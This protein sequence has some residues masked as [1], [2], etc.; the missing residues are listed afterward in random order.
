M[1]KISHRITRNKQ[2][3]YFIRIPTD[4]KQYFSCTFIKRSLKTIDKTTAKEYA[5]SLEYQVSRTLCMLRSRL[6]SETQAATLVSDLLPRK[7]VKESCNIKLSEIMEAYTK[8]HERKWSHKT[9][10]EN[11]GTYKLIVDLLGNMELAVITKQT[12]IDLRGKFELLPA[13][14]RLQDTSHLLKHYHHIRHLRKQLT[15][16][17]W[18]CKSTLSNWFQVQKS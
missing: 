4:L 15:S 17:I 16:P 8:G 2:F 1:S 18:G 12:I 7:K 10:L 9:K 14:Y 11:L 5:A 6:L 13:K 3:N